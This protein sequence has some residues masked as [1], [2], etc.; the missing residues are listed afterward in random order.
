MNINNFLTF[1]NNQM[2]KLI[3]FLIVIFT[4]SA[5]HYVKVYPENKQEAATTTQIL[6]IAEKDSILYKKVVIEEKIY[7]LNIKTNLVEV[8]LE[9]DNSPF[10]SF[11]IILGLFLLI[12]I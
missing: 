2:K 3:L 9:E 7:L 4:L 8:R 1:K 5:C 11:L 6:K 12:F 10:F